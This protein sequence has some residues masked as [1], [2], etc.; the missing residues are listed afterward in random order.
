MTS[1]PEEAAMLSGGWLWLFPAA[2][3]VH[4][5]EEG[6]A[7]EHFYH[8]IRR[9]IGREMSARTFTGLNLAYWS[10]MIAAVRRAR[11]RDDAGW[12]V[13][14]L[15][16]ITAVNGIGHLVGSVV[17]RSYSPGLVSGSVVWIPL[18]LFAVMRARRFLPR[19][20][21]RRS[22]AAGAAVNG[23][24]AVI[25]LPLSHKSKVC[26]NPPRR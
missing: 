12:I 13:P 2:Y 1:Q 11:G 8:W 25:A 21:W 23:G 20:V 5:A 15:G 18:G 26:V 10:A 4:I 6:L 24:I 7:G 9:V 22:I 17:T 3:A 19:A 16:T 14:M